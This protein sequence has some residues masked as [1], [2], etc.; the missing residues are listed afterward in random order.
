MGKK[1]ELNQAIFQIKKSF[2]DVVLKLQTF[3]VIF[4]WF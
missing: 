4:S 2:Q 1:R 3:T